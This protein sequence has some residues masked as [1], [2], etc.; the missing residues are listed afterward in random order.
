LYFFA[1]INRFR[2]G[3]DFSALLGAV[4]SP[5]IIKPLSEDLN[6]VLFVEPERFELSSSHGTVYAFY[7]LS[8]SLIVG[9]GKVSC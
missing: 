5:K 3:P 4:F 6:A 8:F 9:R 2:L 7:M 1:F